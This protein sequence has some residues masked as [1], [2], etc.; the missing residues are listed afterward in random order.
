M[1]FN[2]YFANLLAFT[3]W[4]NIHTTVLNVGVEILSLF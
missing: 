3:S 2:K 4:I 1:K